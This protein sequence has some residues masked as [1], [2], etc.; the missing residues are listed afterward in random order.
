M[1][2]EL[3]PIHERLDKVEKD[4]VEIKAIKSEAIITKRI[5]ERDRKMGRE[6][7]RPIFKPL[8]GIN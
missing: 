4:I 7:R 1:R 6:K 5:Y 3:K 8:P 2:E